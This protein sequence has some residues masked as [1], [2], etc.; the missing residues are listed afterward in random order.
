MSTTSVVTV[1]CEHKNRIQKELARQ[2]RAER[3]KI[4][5][6]SSTWEEY[7]RIKKC[8]E[9]ALSKFFFERVFPIGEKGFKEKPRRG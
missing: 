8:P 1:N 9:S 6:R 2:A 5:G 3:A 4:D 7:N